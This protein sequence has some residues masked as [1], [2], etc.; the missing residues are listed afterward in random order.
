[1]MN[2]AT[3]VRVDG[4][5]EELE[6]RPTLEEAQQ[7]VGGYIELVKAKDHWNNSV[8]LVVDEDGKGK[9]TPINKSI[10]LVYGPSI[11]GGYIVGDVIVL[12]GWKTVK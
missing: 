2:R 7:I 1:M 12:E 11:H 8:T 4:A 5:T 9:N 10:T 3:I 6:G